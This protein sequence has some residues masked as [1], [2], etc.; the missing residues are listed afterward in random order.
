MAWFINSYLWVLIVFIHFFIVSY[1]SL[2]ANKEQVWKYSIYAYLLSLLPWWTLI[3]RYSKSLPL[4]GFIYDFII[5]LSWT[6][7]IILFD[8]KSFNTFHYT[9][10]LFI[11]TGILIFK[12]G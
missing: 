7:C 3:S 6:I 8:G 2:K 5:G 1:L 10:L 11:L 4:S 9:G 12:K